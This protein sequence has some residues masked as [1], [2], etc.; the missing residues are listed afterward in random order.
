MNSRYPLEK[1]GSR[2]FEQ[3]GDK[4]A[5]RSS[6]LQVLDVGSHLHQISKNRYFSTG[7][8]RLASG[9]R[10]FCGRLHLSTLG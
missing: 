10:Y 6:P 4:L 5:A 1:H 2:P 9:L 3:T 7:A 8:P